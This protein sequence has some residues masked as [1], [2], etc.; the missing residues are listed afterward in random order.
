MD[1]PGQRHTER[2]D[3]DPS[4]DFI[5]SAQRLAEVLNSHPAC[6]TLSYTHHRTQTGENQGRRF[7]PGEDGSWPSRYSR[8]DRRTFH[9]PQTHLI[10]HIV[11]LKLR[12]RL[13]S[14]ILRWL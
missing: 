9:L 12:E 3:A 4:P 13:P 1:P 7:D 11:N 5:A 8:H 10:M 6:S 2:S 14:Q